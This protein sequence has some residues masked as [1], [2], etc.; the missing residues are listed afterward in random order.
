[1]AVIIMNM[2]NLQIEMFLLLVVGYLLAKQGRFTKETQNQLSNMV[3]TVFLPCSIIKSFKI[4]LTGEL[5]SQTFIVLVISFGI[6]L[7]YGLFNK[8]FYKHMD[9]KRSVCCKYGTMVSNA[10]FMGMPIAQGVFGDIGLL[11]ASIFLLPQRIFMWSSGLSLFAKEEKGSV[12]RKVITHPCIIS[13]FIGIT[14]MIL[15][16][17]NVFLPIFLDETISLLGGCSTALSMI[18]IGGILAGVDTSNLIDQD[19]MIYCMNRLVILP[20][21]ILFLLRLLNVSTLP[22]NLCVLLSGMPAATTTVILAQKYNS[23]YLFASKMAFVST[24]LSMVTLPML[25][26]IFNLI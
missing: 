10:G 26:F 14:L 20:L 23:D 18:V 8:I 15:R 24:L 19:V 1:M 12:F 25:L 21:I 2:I 4:D 6:H 5:I 16:R 17:Y 3:L 11:Y 13:I 22:A 7:L 9:P